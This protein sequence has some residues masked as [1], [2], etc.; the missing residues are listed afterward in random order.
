MLV[1]FRGGGKVLCTLNRYLLTIR[2]SIPKPLYFSYSTLDTR[3]TVQEDP[4][5]LDQLFGRYKVPILL[6]LVGGV[7]LIG[8]LVSSGV[9]QKTLIKSTQYPSSAQS[10]QN[11]SREIK[12]DISGAVARPGVYSLQSTSRVEDAIIAA[13]GV[14]ED[15]NPEYLSKS[16]NL[17]QIVSDGMKIYVPFVG[18]T[19][20]VTGASTSLGGSEV[21]SLNQATSSQL[22]SLPGVG[23]ATS[24]KIIDNRPYSSVEEVLSKKAVSRSVY[25]K[26]KDKVSI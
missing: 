22:E 11:I 17:A 25:Q 3:I 18:E 2:A 15:A 4:N 16:I 7:L 26:I 20:Q 8:G 21:I 23:P 5:P 24:Q 6:S 14:T 10:P 12:I 1:W 19:G 13:G 9:L